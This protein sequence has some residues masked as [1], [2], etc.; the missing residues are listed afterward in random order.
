M[1][2][3]KN[4]TTIIKSGGEDKLAYRISNL[5]N[6]T[7]E[8][9][10][11]TSLKQYAFYNDNNLIEIKCNN[12][13][14]IDNAAFSYCSQLAS[15]SL[16]IV[17]TIGSQAFNSCPAL[18][19]ISLPSVTSI[20]SNAFSYCS[21]LASISFPSVRTI[22]SSA[23][24]DCSQLISISLPSAYFIDGYTFGNCSS[25]VSVSL[26][27]ATD[28]GSS[29]F[30]GCTSL[31]SITLGYASRV[32]ILRSTNAIPATSSHHVNIYVPVNLVASYR[33]A[34][35]WST[36][37]NN[38]YISILPIDGQLINTSITNGTFSGPVAIANNGTAT[39]TITA[40]SGYELPTSVSVTGASYT[41]SNGVITLSN[42]TAE[43]NISA[44]C[45]QATPSGYSVVVSVHP[46]ATD[47]PRVSNNINI[48]D[49]QNGTLLDTLT[50]SN[51][52]CYE[53]NTKSATVTTTTGQL[54]ITTPDTGSDKSIDSNVPSS[55][56]TVVS[57]SLTGQFYV[58]YNVTANGT[59]ALD[60][61]WRTE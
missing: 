33:T 29:V 60:I 61:D 10:E 58:L 12:L 11:I 27:S 35:N 3:I 2:V 36:L 47:S 41:Y 26:P 56:I 31:T 55:G 22:G 6:Y 5:G 46:Y 21:S 14:T 49:G 23:F 13:L 51:D 42:P 48:Y 43:V 7:Y 32:C 20:S 39:I 45:P 8:N 52:D 17:A 19:S 4:P 15:I 24:R 50:F 40:N 30:T 44:T 57:S 54:Y 1:P 25:L 28:I 9:N 38:G 18:T 59:I 37:Y 16:P 34:T 53:E